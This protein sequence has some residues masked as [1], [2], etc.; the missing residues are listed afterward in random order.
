MGGAGEM[1]RVGPTPSV[2]PTLRQEAGVCVIKGEAA[3]E[4]DGN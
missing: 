1:S 2:V 3:G 4:P